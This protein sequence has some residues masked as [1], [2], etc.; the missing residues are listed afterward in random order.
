VI[1]IYLGI[2]MGKYYVSPVGVISQ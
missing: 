1:F 2:E